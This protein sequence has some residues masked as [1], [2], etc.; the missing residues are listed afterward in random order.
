M[1]DATKVSSIKIDT[2][3]D[4]VKEYPF[5]T[6]VNKKGLI[7][8]D[9]QVSIVLGG[10]G[11]G[12]S[13]IARAL[14]GN[15]KGVKFF[16]KDGNLLSG[17]CSNV[18]VFNEDYVIENFRTYKPD[19]LEPVVLLGKSGS[20][21]DKIK[22]LEEKIEILEKR[23][24][25]IKD[26]VFSRLPGGIESDLDIQICI[27]TIRDYIN[28][29]IENELD[30]FTNSS[31][32][33]D[34]DSLFGNLFDGDGK[35]DLNMYL[36]WIDLGCDIAR[37]DVYQSAHTEEIDQEDNLVWVEN[38]NWYL[39]DK[40]LDYF[41]KELG[42]LYGV[43]CGC[44]YE[45]YEEVDNKGNYISYVD[46]L[47]E[48]H[49][50]FCFNLMALFYKFY[51]DIYSKLDDGF[52]TKGE[53][54]MYQVLT[55][56][57]VKLREEVND[58]RGKLEY[59]N[60][61]NSSEEVIKYM[62]RW[63]RLVFGESLI[64]I[65]ANSQLG[66]DLKNPKG[67]II[68]PGRLSLG[69]QNILALCYFFVAKVSGG[70]LGNYGKS[71]QIILLDDPVSSFDY[72]NKYG[73]MQVLNYIAGL[74]SGSKSESKMLVMTHD[75]VTARELSNAIKHRVGGDKVKCCRII[76]SQ[77]V[78]LE[79]VKLDSLD[80]YRDILHKMFDVA[81]QKGK[82]ID[83]ISPNEVRRVWE[84]FLRFELGESE[85]SSR[86]ALDRA[87]CFYDTQSAEYEFLESFISYVYINQDSHSSDQ[88]L[89]DNFDLI[90]ILGRR[91][92][93]KHICQIILF[94]RLVAPH[95]IPSRLAE[96]LGEIAGYRKALDD[97]YK[98]DVLG[99]PK[100]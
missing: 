59:E 32:S 79:P 45:I 1:I 73:V 98:V 25:G 54:L 84:A 22:D 7:I 75:P 9:A 65:E 19:Y 85:I 60:K 24:L 23:K 29:C 8:D 71:N 38:Q 14:S 46:G 96:N 70:S 91:E 51:P 56:Q 86:N 12:K 55:S 17:D 81:T 64:S 90:P 83:F 30:G 44:I 61:R 67:Q 20:L 18:H 40:S 4:G 99:Q 68:P 3:Y 27:F 78:Y 77:N 48:D 63:L 47:R 95:H 100:G 58:L 43:S 94:M 2:G 5:F 10:N 50:D 33:Y 92:F 26:V 57:I 49:E 53:R 69:E 39:S 15:N 88:M 6:R 80:E 89:F 21:V 42:K 76:D 16:D 97:I 66:Y 41:D 93:E 72:G 82:G 31:Y 87:S 13:T 11:S 37:A 52:A 74:I 34:I 35:I 62:N 28:S 36:R